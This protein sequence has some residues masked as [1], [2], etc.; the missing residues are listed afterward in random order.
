LLTEVER[1]RKYL[2]ELPDNFEFPLFNSARAVESQRQ[3]GYRT[4]ASAAREIVD[5][6]IE[7]GANRIHIIF[8]HPAER[9][10]RQR[11]DAV[12]CV[13]FI[14]DGAGMLPEMVR[15]ALSWGGGT[16]F[17]DP[18]FI[19]RFGFGLPNASINQT[20]R[21]EVYS[22]IEGATRFT[23][24]WL[25]I[26]NV[27]AYSVQQIPATVE[28]DLPDFVQQYLEREKWQ[29]NHGTV[30][31]W[32]KPDRLSR[33][34]G[35]AL[36]EHLVDDFGVTYRYLLKSRELKVEGVV[37][38]PVD[39]LFL[40]KDARH[41]LPPIDGATDKG[42]AQLTAELAIPVK[43]VVD[44]ETGGKHL[45]RIEKPEDLEDPTV[46]RQGVISLRVAR[47][48]LGFAASRHASREIDPIDEHSHAR[49][50][51]RKPRRGMSFVRA[52]REIE[53]VDVFPRRTKEE[54]SGLGR[55]PL[56]QG[57]AYHWGVEVKFDP[58]LDDV[59]GIAN[60]KQTVRP[61][62]DFWKVLAEV[63]VDGLLRRE[64]VW[65]SKQRSL[66]ASTHRAATLEDKRDT[67]SPAELAAQ[68]GDVALGTKPRVPER[69]REQAKKN[70]D[71]R[72]EE[73]A[74]RQQ[75][76]TEEV[77]EALRKQAETRPYRVEYVDE[78]HGFLYTPDFDGPQV[79]VY[80][81]KRHPFFQV[82]YGSLLHVPGGGLAKEAVDLLLIALAKGELS[83][84]EQTNDIYRAQRETL[85]SPFLATAM[86]DLERRYAVPPIEEE[87]ESDGDEDAVAA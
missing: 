78:E 14:D 4:T 20:R 60:D 63:E 10:S 9:K 65:Q 74:Q 86:R 2:S 16:H 12:S 62:E 39:P 48:P 30:V 38:E 58:S 22:R 23:K 15:Y 18:D 25:D 3:S 51:I 57:Y 11:R 49:F 32:D 55:W 59:F 34:T 45:H 71:R 56:L 47:L 28:A 33:R 27:G 50:E 31:V 29:L 84:N 67:P 54:T 13:A 5:N 43:Y 1:Q 42:G 87:V 69:K 40:D 83:D 70:Q 72:A 64:N 61:I 37:V 73:E 7:A 85:W 79:V 77:L 80:I 36:K 6:A 66:R 82:L 17:D 52:G 53:T 24:A 46:V 81:N 8:D 35:A 41:Y 44:P 21:V 76:P 19:G 26:N 75:K 68:A